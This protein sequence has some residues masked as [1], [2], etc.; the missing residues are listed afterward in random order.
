MLQTQENYDFIYDVVNGK[1]P[2]TNIMRHCRKK[3]KM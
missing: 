2:F 1:K 3:K